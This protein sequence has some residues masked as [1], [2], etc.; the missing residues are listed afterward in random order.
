M[1]LDSNAIT[2]VAHTYFALADYERALHWYGTS[3]PGLYMDAVALA[4]MG[5]N[6]EASA[7][8]WTRR[9]LFH[10]LPA[11]MNALDAYL[12]NDPTRAVSALES[13]RDMKSRD[14][15]SIYYLARQAAKLGAVELGNDL[16]EQSVAA[17]YWST[18]NIMRDPWL[19]SLRE[20]TDFL[21]I[22]EVAVQREAHSRSAFLN[23]GGERI[24]TWGHRAA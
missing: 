6:Q 5:R 1:E 14:P 13:G 4:T 21:R 10:T 16:L 17:G 20:T 23:A 2:S 15:E 19:E 9:D 7:L 22:Y 3:R 8:L 18:I 12:R 11:Q 24:L